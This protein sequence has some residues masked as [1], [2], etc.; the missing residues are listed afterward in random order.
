[1]SRPES[2][3]QEINYEEMSLKDLRA[4]L[5]KSNRNRTF[6]LS[7]KINDIINNKLVNDYEST[8]QPIMDEL[9]KKLDS[10]F[11]EFNEITDEKN[12]EFN[13]NESLL[14]ESI[15]DSFAEMRQRQ[16]SEMTELEIQK[17]S[18]LIREKK[19]SPSSVQQLISLSIKLA[20]RQEF[21]KAIDVDHE[22][23]IL[24]QK[25][26]DERLYQIELKYK[27]LTDSLLQKFTLELNGLQGKLDSG[28]NIIQ[29]QYQQQILN[30][31]KTV[32]ITVKSSLLNSINLANSKVNKKEKQTE[33]T[34]RLN[35]F[36][37][38]KALENGMS[39]NLTFEQQ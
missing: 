38:K 21:D 15:E 34:S 25:E 37:I 3:T 26:A 27:K 33:I 23:E 22:A 20:D 13:Q 39:K 24:Q 9:G 17:R 4:E 2:V 7:R 31:Q 28:M 36:V 11:Q 35:N 6:D 16:L 18:E 12:S 14:R 5:K 19:R 29:K 10:T 32:E 1:M 8:I 30:A